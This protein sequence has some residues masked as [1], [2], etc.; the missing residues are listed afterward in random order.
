[1]TALETRTATATR[2]WLR[3]WG[4]W[5]HVGLL[6]GG[7]GKPPCEETLTCPR[8]GASAGHAGTSGGS[9]G[10]TGL[11]PQ[12]GAGGGRPLSSGGVPGDAGKDDTNH[13]GEAG[14]S[15]HPDAGEGGAVPSEDP[16][17][18]GEDGGGA[19]AGAAGASEDGP[20]PRCNILK[21]FQPPVYVA[22]LSSDSYSDASLTADG[23]KMVVWRG[24]DL[25]TATRASLDDPF[26]PPGTAPLMAVPAARFALSQYQ[27]L[28]KVSADQLTLYSAYGGQNVITI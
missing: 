15:G 17:T 28:P 8:S 9:D 1:M 7:C 19:P 22:S 24:D 12:S 2:R 23:R 16:G 11:E 3:N 6:A 26:G 13:A 27:E 10:G 20:E 25:A 4:V 21:P 5:A 14:T 18:G